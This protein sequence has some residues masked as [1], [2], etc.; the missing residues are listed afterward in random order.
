MNDKKETIDDNKCHACGADRGCVVGYFLGP[1]RAHEPGGWACIIELQK[2]VKKLQNK[3]IE[4][5]N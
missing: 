3:I 4:L 1:I 2:Q 5:E